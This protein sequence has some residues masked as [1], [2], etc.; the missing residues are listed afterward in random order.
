MNPKDEMGHN[1]RFICKQLGLVE[2]EHYMFPTQ[3]LIEE[4]PEPKFLCLLYNSLDVFLTTTTGEGFGLTVLE[5]M[6]CGCP[7]IAPY[8]TSFM[9][10]YKNQDETENYLPLWEFQL[11]AQHMDNVVREQCSVDEICEALYTLKTGDKRLAMAA[12]AQIFATGLDWDIIV[13]QWVEVFRK[14]I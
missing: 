7:V 5:A 1:L 9:E 14:L 4:Q 10:F 6:R 13:G 2:N 12:N 8:S 3:G 11:M